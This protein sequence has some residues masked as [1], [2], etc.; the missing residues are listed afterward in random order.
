MLD[1]DH[2]WKQTLFIAEFNFS[3]SFHTEPPSHNRG[4]VNISLPDAFS[5]KI[6]VPITLTASIVKPNPVYKFYFGHKI[7]IFEL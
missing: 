2:K 6:V 3:P 4:K 5:D 1:H 7:P